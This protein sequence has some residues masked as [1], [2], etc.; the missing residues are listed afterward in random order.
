MAFT[1]ETK[2]RAYAW[3]VHQHPVHGRTVLL[4]HD[5][6]VSSLHHEWM[7]GRNGFLYRH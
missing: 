6:D 2:N 1:S 5:E 3:A 7:F 4:I